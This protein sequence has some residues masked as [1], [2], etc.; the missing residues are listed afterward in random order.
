LAKRGKRRRLLLHN[1]APDWSNGHIHN[2]DAER[3]GTLSG[4]I[5]RIFMSSESPGT[6]SDMIPTD[7]LKESRTQVMCLTMNLNQRTHPHVRTRTI[8]FTSSERLTD[9]AV[10][11]MNLIAEQTVVAAS[12][13][14]KLAE[15]IVAKNAEKREMTS[16]EVPLDIVGLKKAL[17]RLERYREMKERQQCVLLLWRARRELNPGPPGFYALFA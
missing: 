11:A 4:A 3:L 6:F 13:T 16:A 12:G 8:R 7:E 9:I 10:T 15:G 2:H 1:N 14:S 5:E 17:G